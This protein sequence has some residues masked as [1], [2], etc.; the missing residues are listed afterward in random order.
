MSTKIAFVSVPDFSSCTL[1]FALPC[2]SD[3][4]LQRYNFF[5]YVFHFFD[6]FLKLFFNV[7][8][9]NEI[10]FS[11]SCFGGGFWVILVK[12]MPFSVGL[13]DGFGRKFVLK[14]DFCKIFRGFSVKKIQDNF[15]L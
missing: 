3:W 7:L 13:D 4:E 11:I 12:K 14:T 9:I 6:F 5:S 10:I 15:P 8:I 1:F 2:P